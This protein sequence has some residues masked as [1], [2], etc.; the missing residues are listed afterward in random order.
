MEINLDE[1]LTSDEKAKFIKNWFRRKRRSEYRRKMFS[2][3][4]WLNKKL[5]KTAP[6]HTPLL[7]QCGAPSSDGGVVSDSSLLSRRVGAAL[8]NEFT[9]HKITPEMD[10]ENKG[11]IDLP[12]SPNGDEMPTGINPPTWG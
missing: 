3:I 4:G 5:C 8:E 7:V 1:I 10:G 9:G 11:R 2:T 12:P 6:R